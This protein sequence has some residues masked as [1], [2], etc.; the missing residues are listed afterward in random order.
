[1]HEVTFSSA[2][3]VLSI[4]SPRFSVLGSRSF[5]KVLVVPYAF[6]YPVTTQSLQPLYFSLYWHFPSEWQYDEAIDCFSLLITNILLNSGKMTLEK[7][8]L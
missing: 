8:D 6:M 3:S 5:S 7:R 2:C 4:L 1:M